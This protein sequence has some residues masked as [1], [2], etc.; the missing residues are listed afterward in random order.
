MPYRKPPQRSEVRK[1]WFIEPIGLTEFKWYRKKM[2]GSWS[3]VGFYHVG[4]FDKTWE[5][6]RPDIPYWAESSDAFNWPFGGPYIFE[7]ENWP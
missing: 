1:P 6:G 7:S 4:R 3:Q 2:G 5:R